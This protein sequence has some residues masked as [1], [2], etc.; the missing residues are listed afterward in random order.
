MS[1]GRVFLVG[2]GPGDPGL[3]TVRA[4]EL[5]A[6]AD[7][8]L[9]DGLV[10]RGVLDLVS[11]KAEKTRVAKGPHHGDRFP[12][13]SINELMIRAARAGK[14]VVRLKGGDALLFSRGG[15]EADTLRRYRVPFEIVPGV[16]SALAGPAYAG[17]PL[18][19]RGYSSSVAFVTGHMSASPDHPSLDWTALSRG[20]DTLVILMGVAKWREIA[21]ALLRAGREPETPVAAVRWATTPR[22]RTTLFTLGE[23][24]RTA[25][26]A[27]LDSPS[28]LVVGRSVG[29]ADRLRWFPRERRWASPGYR[30]VASR[31]RTAGPA[32][33]RGTEG[34]PRSRARSARRS[35]PASAPSRRGARN[36]VSSQGRPRRV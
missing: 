1:R 21:R 15:E 22:Q 10:G 35:A 7:V 30:K 11:P 20:A 32:T 16:T 34:P 6:S 17:I 14:R 29:Q 33:S 31:L 23:S 3:L 19:E 36:R 25:V 9:Y 4:R 5:L 18:T 8:V 28:V 24:T 26:R 2:A 12:Q 13:A 27:R